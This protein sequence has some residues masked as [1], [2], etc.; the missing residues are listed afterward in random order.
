MTKL[1]VPQGLNGLSIHE[2]IVTAAW[3]IWWRR[4]EVKHGENVPL[5]SRTALSIKAMV[6]NCVKAKKKSGGGEK[7]G[8]MKPPSVFVKLNTDA[9]VNFG[10]KEGNDGVY[11]PRFHWP[12]SGGL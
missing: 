12:I 4:R 1:R 3:F 5:A 10:H 8:W 6:M 2:V 7:K 11:H 9:A